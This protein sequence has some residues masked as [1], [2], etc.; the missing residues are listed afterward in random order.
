M[1]AIHKNENSYSAEWENSY[2]AEWIEYCRENGIPFK[3]VNCYQSDI[4]DQ[5][6]DCD[7]L[8]WHFHHAI[9]SD[10]LFARQL[11]Y[12]VESAGKFVFPDFD[13]MWHFDDKVGQKY[14]LEAIGAPLVPSYVFYSKAEALKW[15]NENTFPKVF[16]LRVGAS[17]RNVR[18]VR[19]KEEAIRLVKHAFG[20]GFKQY[21]SLLCLKE[22]YIKH[23]LGETTKLDIAK[24]IFRLLFKTEFEKFAGRDKGYIYFQ[25]FIA[26]NVSDTRVVVVDN[27]AF[28]AKRLVRKNDFRASGSHI[29]LYNK[30]LIDELTLKI[31]FDVAKKL[32]LQCVAYDF[33]YDNG[34]PLIVE[35]SYGTSISAYKPCPGYWDSELNFYNG[36]FNFCGWMVDKV[37]YKINKKVV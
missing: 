27:K 36:D 26:N 35:I 28:G 1:I 22:T 29:A 10:I 30:E 32:N 6:N 8:M 11:L 2:N 4:I 37:I 33:V 31:S 9:P 20:S 34:S 17:S 25:D 15:V 14:L 19:T 16:K 18:L 13:T 5:L 24:G 7:A 21:N 12:S 23:K 3:I